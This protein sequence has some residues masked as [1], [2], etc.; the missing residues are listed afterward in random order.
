MLLL[1]HSLLMSPLTAEREFSVSVKNIPGF[2]DN[3]IQSHETSV[4]FS[5]WVGWLPIA[6]FQIIVV[7]CNDQ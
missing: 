7:I 3:Q 2:I 5:A 4:M 1:L 6:L